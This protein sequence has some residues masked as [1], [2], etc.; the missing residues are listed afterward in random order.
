MD[1]IRVG[2]SPWPAL[3]GP[4]PPLVLGSIAL[5]EVSGARP[6]LS[7]PSHGRS[8]LVHRRARVAIRHCR[9]H[10]FSRP[11]ELGFRA[12]LSVARRG[13]HLGLVATAGEDAADENEPVSAAPLSLCC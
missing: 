2:S 9:G 6:K 12:P 4:S 10:L 8:R 7:L 13:G 1:L 3:S 5:L 11:V